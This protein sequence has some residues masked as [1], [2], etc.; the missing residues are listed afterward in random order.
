MFLWFNEWRFWCQSKV[1]EI[2]RFGEEFNNDNELL[3]FLW[4]VW[5]RYTVYLWNDCVSVPL[6]RVHPGV[7]TEV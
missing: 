6:R 5:D 4:R 1:N 2:V 7:K 3:I